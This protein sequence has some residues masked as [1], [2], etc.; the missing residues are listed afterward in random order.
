MFPYDVPSPGL[1]STIY[2]MAEDHGSIGTMRGS[3]RSARFLVA[4]WGSP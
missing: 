4:K 2:T 1:A 3:L